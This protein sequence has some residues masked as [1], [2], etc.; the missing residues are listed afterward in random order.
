MA[1][2]KITR[3]VGGK[4]IKEIEGDYTIHTNNFTMNSGGKGSFTSDKQIVFGTPLEEE[5]KVGC[6]KKGLW[7][8]DRECKNKINKAYLGDTVFF[9]I[10]T[11]DIS[12]GKPVATRLI[13]SDQNEKG[14]NDS[15]DIG[16]E[17]KGYHLIN[18]R[19]VYEGKVRIEL[20]LN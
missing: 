5:L 19:P 11:R 6:L 17:K 8:S 9:Q 15:V 14:K 20:L 4:H 18:Y 16:N 13:D 7:Y 10:E 3:I 12:N 1:G 2:G